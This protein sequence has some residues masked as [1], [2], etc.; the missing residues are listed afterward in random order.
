[1]RKKT[2]L[3][4]AVL[5]LLLA[6][7][8]TLLNGNEQEPPPLNGDRPPELDTSFRETVF[9][10]PD[11]KWQ[12]LIPVRTGIP[13]EEGIAKA[14]VGYMVDGQVPQELLKNGLA[15]LLPANTKV[16]GMSIHNGVARLDLSEDVLKVDPDHERMMVYGLV[17]TLT[18]FPTI[19]QVEILVEGEKVQLPGGLLTGE[20]LTREA[21]LNLEVSSK[22]T[23]F[24][25][26][27][28]VTL[29]YLFPMGDYAYY[30][31]VT[32]VI[33]KTNDTLLAVAQELLHGPAPGSPLFTAL[34][35]GISLNH[36]EINDMTL[37]IDVNGDLAAS[38]GQLAA[39][40]IRHQLALTFTE[41]P[42]IMEVQVLSAGEKPEF[43]T[44]I[45]FPDVFSRPKQWNLTGGRQ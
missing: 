11:P 10:L 43:P 38:G 41:I 44:G 31:P 7:G 12:V 22:V 18:E 2:C 37:T 34:P 6:S 15:A 45:N 21:G 24:E 13:R 19:S 32:R 33:E 8:C 29:Y 9:Y 28:K 4:L 20:R 5:L 26:T 23:D 1:M 40:R 16:L 25:N 35:Q 14:T 42:E 17:F 3:L 30:V 39:D 27:E 36:I